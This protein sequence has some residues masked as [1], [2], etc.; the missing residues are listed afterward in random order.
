MCIPV[1]RLSLIFLV[2]VALVPLEAATVSRQNADA[3]AMKMARI[4]RQADLVERAG[5]LRT[6]LTEDELNS[7][8]VYSAEPLLPPGFGLPQVTIV[9]DGRLAAQ[10]VVDMNVVAGRP[11]A[12]GG[13]DPLS[14]LGGKVPVAVT[15]VLHTGDG[16]ARFEVQSAEAAGIP[17]PVSLV[18]EMANYYSRT[19]EE[20]EGVRLDEVFALPAG[21]LRIDIGQG[22]AVVVQ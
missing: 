4:Q 20:P 16:M 5:T 18:Q 3:F 7:W 17:I 13:L 14:L 22:Q 8:F 9:G 11:S 15:G 21:I 10:T 12:G 19:P 6:P 2:V 1:R